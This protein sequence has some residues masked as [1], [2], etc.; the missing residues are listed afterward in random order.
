[1][2]MVDKGK[3]PY[4]YLVAITVI[5]GSLIVL[6]ALLGMR[7]PF[8]VHFLLGYIGAMLVYVIWHAVL[9]KGWKRSLVMF[10]LSFI[11]AFSAEAMGVNFGLVF[12]HYYYSK[13]LGI[14][15]FGVPLL[16]ALAWEPILYA[17]FCITDMLSPLGGSQSLPSKK[18]SSFLWLAAIGALATT[19]WDMMIDPIAVH[20]GWWVWVDGGAYM[21]YIASGVPI[22]N[23]LGW[24]CVA[25]VIHLVYRQ[26]TNGIAQVNHSA[27]LTYYGPL[28]FYISLFLT[29]FGVAIT[30]LGRPEVALVGVLAMGPFIVIALTNLPLFIHNLR[31]LVSPATHP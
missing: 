20:Q 4:L 16:A 24:L 1:M 13:V 19:A 31:N 25:F 12:G 18:T 27:S 2:S 8:S 17:A 9:T 10:G 21:P 22:T 11:V 26:L 30:I 28:V 5:S 3:A 29:S 15:L 7:I 6:N 14:S 23:F